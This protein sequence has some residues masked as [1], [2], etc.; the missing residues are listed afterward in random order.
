MTP[1]PVD[2]L[3]AVGL[4]VTGPRVSVLEVLAEHPHA[5]AA[6]VLER[7]RDRTATGAVGVSVQGVYDVLSTLD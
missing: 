2:L 3:R 1:A 5:D 6:P 4:R 7:V